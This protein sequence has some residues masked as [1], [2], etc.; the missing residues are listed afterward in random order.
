MDSLVGENHSLS[1]IDLFCVA[2]QDLER[3]TARLCG[4]NFQ[5]CAMII[6]VGQRSP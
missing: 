2:V 1:K 6:L 3:K 5:A 4:P